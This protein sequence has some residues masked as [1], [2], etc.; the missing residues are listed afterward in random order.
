MDCFKPT[1][2]MESIKLDDP[3]YTPLKEAQAE[4]ASRFLDILDS[5][6]NSDT[7]EQDVTKDFSF[8]LGGIREE[9]KSYEVPKYTVVRVDR[10]P[11]ITKEQDIHL[12]CELFGK[13]NNIN[14]DHTNNCAWIQFENNESAEECIRGSRNLNLFIGAQLSLSATMSDARQHVEPSCVQTSFENNCWQN[15]PFQLNSVHRADYSLINYSNSEPSE[16]NYNEFA[17]SNTEFN[18]YHTDYNGTRH[19]F[20]ENSS[21]FPYFQQYPQYGQEYGTVQNEFQNL[22]Y[23]NYDH[24]FAPPGETYPPAKVQSPENIPSLEEQT[25]MGKKKKESNILIASGFPLDVTPY[26]IFRLFSLYGNVTRIKIM[27][28]KRDTALIQFMDCYQAKLAKL[29][30]NGCQFGGKVI[31]VNASK[32][33]FIIMPKK[34]TKMESEERMLAQDFSR[35]KE[36]RYKIAGSRNFQNIAP[37]SKVLHLSNLP[38][39]I[40]EVRL[41]SVFSTVSNFEKI[42]FFDVAEKIMAH[43]EFDSIS[44]AIEVII[45]FHNYNI[46]GRYIKISFS[47]NVP[48]NLTKEE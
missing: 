46:D 40:D 7:E 38:K 8:P 44:T 34:G 29:Y 27:F 15:S 10:L 24:G 36:H 26:K 32:S 42:K 25:S 35:S 41:Q 47:K 22:Y 43:A 33:S 18:S 16:G 28:K 2:F 45:A 19:P 48:E 1:E 14:I 12:A 9:S 30:L 17:K 6:E 23:Q 20:E 13:I 21:Y 5:P 3:A 37:P 4:E 31:K 11:Q 39:E